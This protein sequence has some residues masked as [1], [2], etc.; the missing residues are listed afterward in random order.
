MQNLL[1]I[2]FSLLFIPL[3]CNQ[4]SAI[5]KYGKHYQAHHDFYSLNKVV[6][7]MEPGQDTS[8][9]KHIL[10]E[11]IDMGF[12]YRYLVDSIGENK[13]AVGAVFHIDEAGRV[14]QQWTGEICE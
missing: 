12:D 1:I 8:Y 11:P 3:M 5:E 14:D 10:G 9:V 4:E 13:C 6:E 7:L 2:F